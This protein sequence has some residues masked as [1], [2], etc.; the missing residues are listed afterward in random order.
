MNLGELQV[1]SNKLELRNKKQGNLILLLAFCL[2][3]SLL[4]KW[5]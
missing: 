4:Q 2:F 5:C 3:A 1:N